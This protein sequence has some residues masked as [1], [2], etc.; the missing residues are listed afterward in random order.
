MDSFTNAASFDED[1]EEEYGPDLE[2]AADVHCSIEGIAFALCSLFAKKPERLILMADTIDPEIYASC[3]ETAEA[4]LSELNT[5]NEDDKNF[6]LPSGLT[7]SME[8]MTA[9]VLW[10]LFITMRFFE[11]YNCDSGGRFKKTG[12]HIFHEDDQDSLQSDEI[13]L[14]EQA[15]EDIKDFYD[16][17]DS[18][19]EMI[20]ATLKF[21]LL[22]GD[23]I[24]NA[25]ESAL[26]DNKNI[27]EDPAGVLTEYMHKTMIKMHESMKNDGIDPNQYY[28][29]Q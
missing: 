26:R 13:E 7:I 9:Q 23:W 10:P 11:N 6:I 5:S 24:H 3:L 16:F 29:Y 21:P 20:C 2:L 1:D 27:F 28:N 12:Q 19:A 4:F 17:I 18:G 22:N 14:Q 15:S 8:G 25:V